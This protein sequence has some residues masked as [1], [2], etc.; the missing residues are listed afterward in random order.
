M[1]DEVQPNRKADKGLSSKTL[2]GLVDDALLGV[3]Q[4]PVAEP[5]FPP[6]ALIKVNSSFG[7]AI[8][9]HKTFNDMSLFPIPPN[10]ILLYLDSINVFAKDYQTNKASMLSSSKKVM[11]LR[12][13]LL[14]ARKKGQHKF[15]MF[16]RFLCGDQIIRFPEGLTNIKKDFIR[17]KP[18]N[19]E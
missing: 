2:Q 18:D 7:I 13:L 17:C 6:G 3:Q 9:D 12:A 5:I 10:T 19:Q 16:H 15:F 4:V 8:T 11:I 1:S 14:M